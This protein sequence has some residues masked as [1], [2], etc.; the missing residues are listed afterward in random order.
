M[1]RNHPDFKE[2]LENQVIAI[3]IRLERARYIGVPSDKGCADSTT[4]GR[5]N[6]Q[7]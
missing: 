2:K 4:P 7:K 5:P 3:D 1:Y 6:G